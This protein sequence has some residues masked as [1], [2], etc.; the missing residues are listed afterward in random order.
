MA[1]TINGDGTITGADLDVD[2]GTLTVDSVNNRVG[3][4]TT[5]PNGTYGTALHIHSP[6]TGSSLHL[7]DAT[8]GSAVTD[9]TEFFHYAFDTY[10]YNREATGNFR[11]YTN[12]AERMRID[13]A[14]RVGINTDTPLDRLH[15]NEDSTNCDLRISSG[16]G[17]AGVQIVSANTSFGYINFGDPE[18]TNVGQ[19]NYSHVDNDLGF[20]TG[21]SQNVT[22]DSSGHLIVPSGITL[23]TASATTYSAA[24]TLDDYEEGT[25]TPEVYGKTTAGVAT[26]NSRTGKYTKVGNT[27]HFSVYINLAGHTGS[28]GMA[29]SGLPFTSTGDDAIAAG[30]AY[31]IR[32]NGHLTKPADSVVQLAVPLSNTIIEFWSISTSSTSFID[33]TLA[34]DVAWAGNIVGWYRTA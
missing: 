27:V 3:V 5:T 14:G 20:S 16:S 19:I 33:A 7:T 22:I 1:V 28:G 6:T 9:G 32:N 25:F 15:I 29:I 21:G 23:G 17:F 31:F 2:A 26:Y 34:L 18:S 10:I 30:G 24:N 8:S 13:S 11:V 4:G 12:G